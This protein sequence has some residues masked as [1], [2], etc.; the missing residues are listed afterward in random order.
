MHISEEQL[1]ANRE[2]SKRS[3]GPVTPEG[4]RKVAMNA[5]K[6]SFAGQTMLLQ[7][8]EVEAFNRHFESFRKEYRPGTATEQF[9]V[10]SLAEISWS[11]QQVRAALA[12][13]MTIAGNREWPDV[14]ESHTPEIGTAI[15][16]SRAVEIAAKELNLFSI[17]ES[18][19]MRSFNTTRKELIQAQAERK[20]FEKSEMAE[21]ARYRKQCKLNQDPNQ[22]A[23]HPSEFGF[24]CSLEAIDAYIA[25]EDRMTKLKTMAA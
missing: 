21:A 14:H 3:T 11:T 5:I 25:M 19:K 6:H 23:W 24:D 8:H 1:R 2:N 22:P 17:Y 7:S 12:N 18:R 4:R 15:A 10:Q 9:L 20:A 13:A 16:R